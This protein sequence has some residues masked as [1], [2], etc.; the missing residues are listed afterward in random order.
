MKQN[1]TA[2]LRE[3][4]E[5]M[6]TQ[7]LDEMLDRE[8]HGE[9]IDEDAVRMIMSVLREREKEYHVTITPE[10]EEAWTQYRE[11][12]EALE[13]E[14]SAVKR[15]RTWLL[16]AASAVAVL[17]LLLSVVPQQ[18]SAERFW[19]RL[20]RWTDEIM[21]FFGSGSAEVQAEKDIFQTENEGLRQ[22]Y[23]AAVA[24]GITEP[25]VPAWLPVGST[26]LELKVERGTSKTVLY[27]RFQDGD[28]EITYQMHI[29]DMD[30]SHKYQKD[31][32]QIQELEMNGT[33]YYIMRNNDFWSVVW[34][35]KN[36]ECSIFIHCQEEVLQKILGSI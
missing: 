29:F 7:Q 3:L 31:D 14:T 26:L 35:K 2:S 12:V 22:I 23:D 16:R 36:I 17:V 8:L 11:N 9:S 18:V 15:V 24:E 27:A 25:E 1:N 30:I 20:V 28:Q 5:Q 19:D 33:T 4:L 34:T 6:S 32:A 21:E 13:R 10:M